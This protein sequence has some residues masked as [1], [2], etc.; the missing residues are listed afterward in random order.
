MRIA[1]LNSEYPS[2]SHTFIEREVRHLRA[3][4]VEITTFSVRPPTGTATLGSA[5]EQAARETRVVLRSPGSLLGSCVHALLTRPLGLLRAVVEGQ[6]MSPPGLRARL[7]H[8]AYAVEAARLARMLRREGLTH[9]HVHMANNGAAIARLATHFDPTLSYSLSIHGSAEFFHVDSWALASKARDARFIR[10]ISNFCRAQVMTF[11]H[12]SRWNNLHVVR[13]GIDTDH[14]R[15]AD[16][17]APDTPL[18]LVTVGRLH[19]IKGYTVL[20]EALADLY[21][22]G[23]ACRLTMVGDGPLRPMIERTIQSLDLESCVTLAGPVGAEELVRYLHDAHAMV[24]SSFMEGVPVVLMEA[25]ACELAVIATRVGGIPELVEHGVS[26]LLVDPASSASL[27]QAI[28]TIARDPQKRRSLG[29]AARWTVCDRYDIRQSAAQ[30]RDILGRY[31]GE[32]P[33]PS[34]HTRSRH[35]RTPAVTQP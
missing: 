28:E 24:V 19:P 27:A 20:L 25:M 4:G 1:Y 33:A 21:A 22:R 18:R 26:G 29:Q 9:V 11:T 17:P 14:F 31:V 10:C 3:Q 23:I 6:R 16:R 5:H 32:V 8:A 12:P 13:C 7:W 2:L 35:T 34:E 30:M 15:P